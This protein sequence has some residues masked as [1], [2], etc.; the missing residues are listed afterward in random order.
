MVHHPVAF[1]RVA[2]SAGSE[3]A[4]PAREE[5]IVDRRRSPVVVVVDEVADDRG[6]ALRITP[7]VGA[8]VRH[9]AGAVVAERGVHDV[10]VATRVGPRVAEAVVLG[11]H[12]VDDHITAEALTDVEAR[13]RTAAAVAVIDLTVVRVERVHAVVAVSIR[14]EIRTAEVVRSR[15]EESVARV[16]ARGHVLDDDT[17]G[18][19]DADPVLELEPTVE[20]DLIAI[21]AAD[22]EVRRGDVDRL[23]VGAFG[24]QY[25]IAWVRG[26]D[27]RLDRGV[28]LRHAHSLDFG[29]FSFRRA[30]RS[31][32]NLAR[33]TAARATTAARDPDDRDHGHNRGVRHPT[34]YRH[35]QPP[36]PRALWLADSTFSPTSPA[37]HPSPGIGT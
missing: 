29:G 18:L 34:S 20:H 27:R 13:I 12:R 37:A 16:V 21:G 19:E 15:P 2:D 32:R 9:D 33:A 22:R 8:S 17:V 11:E 10:E 23:A 3:D 4:V 31:C 14:G 26:A 36:R 30:R 28:V 1:D 25:E 6:V 35:R 24:D 7:L 5:R